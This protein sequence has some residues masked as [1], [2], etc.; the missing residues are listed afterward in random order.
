MW[1]WAF[2][3]YKVKHVSVLN[4]V[5]SLK[6]KLLYKYFLFLSPTDVCFTCVMLFQLVPPSCSCLST[7]SVPLLI[8]SSM[9]GSR[10]GELVLGQTY[11]G[12]FC[13]YCFIVCVLEN[14]DAVLTFDTQVHL[15][16]KKKFCFWRSWC[17]VTSVQLSEIKNPTQNSVLAILHFFSFLVWINSN[18]HLK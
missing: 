5:R 1:L 15:I 7:S 4:W 9:K 8:D 12:G 16:I 17:L 6:I 13:V 10:K 14:G 18:C 3:L 11:L 2:W